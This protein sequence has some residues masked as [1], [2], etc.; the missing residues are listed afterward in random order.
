MYARNSADRNNPN[1]NFHLKEKFY[2]FVC[3]FLVRLIYIKLKTNSE[4]LEP[5]FYK[6]FFFFLNGLF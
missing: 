1:Q 6:H 4:G 5:M 3:L 2:L